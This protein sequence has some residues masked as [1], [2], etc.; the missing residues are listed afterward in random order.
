M[1]TVLPAS[2]TVGGGRKVG[3]CTGGRR[4]GAGRRC[5][6]GLVSNCPESLGE[7]AA[8]GEKGPMTWWP[9]EKFEGTTLS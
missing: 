8:R 4:G 9:V 6:H 1:D 7:L 5:T 3:V 2:D